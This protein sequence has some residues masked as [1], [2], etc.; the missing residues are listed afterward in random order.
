MA[1]TEE[2]L[3]NF[4][5]KDKRISIQGLVQTLIISGRNANEIK[6]NCELAKAYSDEIERLVNGVP[7]E[8]ETKEVKE[9]PKEE[10]INWAEIA[11][12]ANIQLPMVKNIKVLEAVLDEYKKVNSGKEY[13]PFD[14]LVKVYKKFGKYPTSMSS[15]ETV[16]K[17][18][19]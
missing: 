16:L 13:S 19:N 1:Y 3:E 4:R 17:I 14:L 11:A 7:C 18:L 8:R 9:K 2:E 10:K 6:E 15:V 12:D 5:K